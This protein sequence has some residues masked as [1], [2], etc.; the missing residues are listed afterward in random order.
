M[1]EMVNWFNKIN[2]FREYDMLFHSLPC[3]VI[4]VYILAYRRY[5]SGWY[6]L[7]IF[8][9]TVTFTY[10]VLMRGL[11]VGSPVFPGSY[12]ERWSRRIVFSLFVF[13]DVMW[14][15]SAYALFVRAWGFPYDFIFGTFAVLW[16]GEYIGAPRPR[17]KLKSCNELQL[18]FWSLFTPFTGAFHL[19]GT[20]D[21]EEWPR[22]LILYILR[23]IINIVMCSWGIYR[24]DWF[25]VHDD[26][27]IIQVTVDNYEGNHH[28]WWIALTVLGTLFT[29]P[30]L[31]LISHWVKCGFPPNEQVSSKYE[32]SEEV[33]EAE[34]LEGKE[35]EPEAQ[36]L[37]VN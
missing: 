17:D 36:P 5:C 7:P 6:G 15:T 37:A 33:D 27:E 9:S 31:L 2:V 18:M 26:D 23:Y 12:R 13:M 34:A 8:I 35:L 16:A 20:E 32:E 3:I 25:W 4:M 30:L 10:A 29:L 24:S 1:R 11:R 22:T 14:R 19:V 21:N 28:G